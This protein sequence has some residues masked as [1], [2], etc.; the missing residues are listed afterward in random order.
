MGS[1]LHM[2]ML[3]CDRQEV[4]LLRILQR[5]LSL[6]LITVIDVR[7]D[8]VDALHTQV[9]IQWR[10]GREPG[11][12][13]QGWARGGRPSRRGGAV[14]LHHGRIVA[15]TARLRQERVLT[16]ATAD[17]KV[18]GGPS[19]GG[20]NAHMTYTDKLAHWRALT[21]QLHAQGSSR[22]NAPSRPSR[23]TRCEAP[24]FDVAVA[25]SVTAAPTGSRPVG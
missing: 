23:A 20:A 19:S 25:D 5:G 1:D 12:V 21:E 9:A 6:D 10:T 3:R 15:C 18:P 8:G 11:H 16:I 17:V 24:D 13:I 4:P 7:D 2:T 22:G 14:V